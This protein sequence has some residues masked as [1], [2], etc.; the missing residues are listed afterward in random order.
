MSSPLDPITLEIPLVSHEA[1][2]A[3]LHLCAM[4]QNDNKAVVVVKGVSDDFENF[5][6]ISIEDYDEECLEEEGYFSSY[7]EPTL[8]VTLWRP[9]KEDGGDHEH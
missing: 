8:W 7:D 9:A 3:A 2:V 5:T 1:I 4:I 6:G